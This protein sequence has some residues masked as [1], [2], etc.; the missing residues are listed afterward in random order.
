MPLGQ[1]WNDDGELAATRSRDLNREAIRELL[2]RG[3]VQFVVADVG[4]G[5]RWIRPAER[6]E[7]WKNEVAGHLADGGRIDL[8]SFPSGLAYTA[9]E[10]AGSPDGIPIV[11]L[12][13]HH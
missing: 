8:D 2:A 10:W 6:F 12:E 5:L 7:F 4:R 9:S 11:L 1:L 13:A 3:S